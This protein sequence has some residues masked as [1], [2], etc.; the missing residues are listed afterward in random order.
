M[1]NMSILL[2]AMLL[3]AGVCGAYNIVAKD[4]TIEGLYIVGPDV[5][6]DS[7][8]YR[9]L[10]Y[11]PDSGKTI[12]VRDT[13]GYGDDV[14]CNGI[15]ADDSFE[16]LYRNTDCCLNVSFD[17]GRNWEDT[18]EDYGSVRS[19]LFTGEV[20][21]NCCNWSIDFGFTFTLTIP[22][23]Y[24]SGTFNSDIGWNRGERFVITASSTSPGIL[25]RFFDYGAAYE[26]IDSFD[27]GCSIFRCG[28][29]GE[30]IVRLEDTLFISLDDC[31]TFV[32]YT[33]LPGCFFR[34]NYT[35]EYEHGSSPGAIYAV[36]VHYNIVPMVGIFGGKIE[37]WHSTDY[38]DTWRMIATHG[39]D[40]SA[41]IAL[42]QHKP[43]TFSFSAFPN[44]FNSS[45]E[46]TAPAGADV[47]IYDLRGNVVFTNAMG[48]RSPRPM[49]KGAE[50]APLQNG[51]RTF[52]WTPDQSIASGI[53]LVRATTD[54]GRT[55][56]KRIVYLK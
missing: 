19:G 18:G 6:L 21:T 11:S 39:W 35:F 37:I 33:V 24:P 9:L 40:S 43:T 10:Y 47:E 44:P 16:V 15:A 20:S 4:N 12:E 30:M 46:I 5:S 23:D 28:G 56:T 52:T 27:H 2:L 49:Q 1:R 13:F 3:G 51:A 41:S 36:G 53:Y 25:Y 7:T 42:N 32:L 26:M 50:T 17:G 48:A 54:D 45:C 14:C 31:T 34:T 22:P 29:I 8:G 55:T 38:G